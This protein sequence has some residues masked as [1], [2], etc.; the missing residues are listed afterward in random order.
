VLVGI[1]FK[2]PENFNCT[3]GFWLASGDR[4]FYVSVLDAVNLC[5]WWNVK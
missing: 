3:F 5:H 1:V 2:G 4:E